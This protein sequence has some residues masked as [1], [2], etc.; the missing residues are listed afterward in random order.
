MIS[1]VKGLAKRDLEGK[2]L[3][4]IIALLAI[5]LINSAIVSIPQYV[6]L[7][8]FL[9]SLTVTEDFTEAM[10]T[11]WLLTFS[12]MFVIVFIIAI[13]AS[14]FVS[15]ILQLGYVKFT[16]NLATTGDKA[17]EAI[18]DGFK[19]GAYLK[20]VKILFLVGVRILLWTLPLIAVQLFVMFVFGE[21]EAYAILLIF[22]SFGYMFFLYSRILN[23]LFVTYLLMDTSVNYET[24]SEYI[25]KSK[26]LIR[27][28]KW[29]FIGL[30]LS[31][32]LWYLLIPFTL[33]LIMIYVTPYMYQS[34]TRFYLE[35]KEEKTSL[36]Y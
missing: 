25:V 6:M 12:T 5:Y 16:L 2:F 26:E 32:I 4:A 28:K 8:N 18:F 22:V 7:P 1:R 31:F 20:R 21:D 27:G 30:V 15:S 19:D 3:Y 36:S 10:L 34:I 17:I 13:V 11:E 33:G 24:T 14:I 9:E 23:Y 29:T 35:L